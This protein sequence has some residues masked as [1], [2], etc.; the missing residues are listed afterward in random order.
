MRCVCVCWNLA[1]QS[2]SVPSEGSSFCMTLALMVQSSLPSPQLVTFQWETQ[3]HPHPHHHPRMCIGNHLIL[4]ATLLFPQPFPQ[5]ETSLWPPYQLPTQLQQR[6]CTPEA[7]CPAAIK[8][9]MIKNVYSFIKSH[10]EKHMDG[11]HFNFFLRTCAP[12]KGS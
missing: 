7:P 5:L 3:T 4:S 1:A 12:A 10:P 11:I 8:I 9:W 6:G 2:D